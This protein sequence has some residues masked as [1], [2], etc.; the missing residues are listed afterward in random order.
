MS[1]NPRKYTKSGFR[2]TRLPIVQTILGDTEAYLRYVHETTSLPTDGNTTSLYFDNRDWGSTD[3][4]IYSIHSIAS[5]LTEPLQHYYNNF[6]LTYETNDTDI[7][8]TIP[9]LFKE[10]DSSVNWRVVNQLTIPSGAL[11]IDQSDI[12]TITLINYSGVDVNNCTV[13][14]NYDEL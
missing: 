8:G 11:V 9:Y 10:Y 7:I 4:S 12:L 5:F 2:E 6:T 3:V 14:I 1:Y 13:R